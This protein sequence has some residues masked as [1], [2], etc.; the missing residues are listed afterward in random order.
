MHRIPSQPPRLRPWNRNSA[1]SGA[2]SRRGRR[3]HNG[4]ER[5]TGRVSVGAATRR[6]CGPGTEKAH[7][8]GHCRSGVAAPAGSTDRLSPGRRFV[9]LLET[10]DEHAQ[11]FRPVRRSRNRLGRRTG[12]VSVGTATRRECGPGTEK[13]HDQ[14]PCRGGVATPQEAWTGYRL[15]A[16]SF[17]CWK[18]SMNTRNRSGLCAA[19]ATGSGDGPGGF[20]W[21]R[22]PAA[23]AAREQRKPM[24]KGPVAAGSPLRRK[25]GPAIAWPP[26]RSPA[27]NSR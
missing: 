2:P 16:G 17:A 15:A 25:P 1:G 9:R 8:Q 20:P 24:I 22:R 13:A 12:R 3:S 18:Q 27:G 19:P 4:L 26:V 11:P 23:S 6:D 5:R 7:D 14:G 21:E 10:V